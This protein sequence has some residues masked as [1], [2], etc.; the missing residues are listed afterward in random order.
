MGLHEDPVYVIDVD[1]SGSVSD[2]LE[3]RGDTEVSGAPKDAWN[4]PEFVDT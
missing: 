1:F 2:G 3:K 4:C